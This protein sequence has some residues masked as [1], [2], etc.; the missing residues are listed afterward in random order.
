MS[1]QVELA[2]LSLMPAHG[3]DLPPALVDLAGSLLAQSR[4]R[5]S[6][7]K[8]DEEVARPYACANIAC[9]R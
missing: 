7:L 3:P 4:L 6:T 1:R 5:A 8:A 9:D 2:L